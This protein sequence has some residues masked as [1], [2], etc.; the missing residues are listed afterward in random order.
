MHEMSLAEG[1]IQI[2]EDNARRANAERVTLVRLEVGQFAGVEIPALRFCFDAVTRGTLA[3]GAA[4]EI[5]ELPGS[6]FC[7]DCGVAVEIPD[8]LAPCPTCGGGRLMPEGGD[9][10]RVKDMQVT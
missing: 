10:M 7:F 6:A 4:L 3:E 9:E 2:V 5:D 1:I 8:R